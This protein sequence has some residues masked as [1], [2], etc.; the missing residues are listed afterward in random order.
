MVKIKALSYFTSLIVELGSPVYK[1]SVLYKLTQGTVE[2]TSNLLLTTQQLLNE[3]DI[4]NGHSGVGVMIGQGDH[5]G[6]FQS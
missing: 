6:L 3:V 4:V 5:R 2:A 1:H